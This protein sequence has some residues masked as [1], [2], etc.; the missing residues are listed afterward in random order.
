MI[1]RFGEPV[2]K[3]IAYRHRPGVYAVLL[4]GGDVLLTHQMEP[5]PEVQLP[6]GGINPGE[7][8][9]PAL[10]REVLEETG[11]TIAAPRKLGTYRR[12]AWM[13]EYKLWAEK[14]CHLYLARPVRRL[15][16]PSEEGHTAIWAPIEVAAGIVANEGER[17]CL[18]KLAS[19][20]SGLSGRMQI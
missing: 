9:L 5:T 7:Q 10:H 8:V 19:H 15:G 11:W 6:G 16:P 18:E 20:A 3:E 17:H 1:R 4:L 12:F 13:P 2:E 14:V